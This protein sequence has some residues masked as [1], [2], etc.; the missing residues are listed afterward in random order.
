[1]M[2]SFPPRSGNQK[3]NP[4]PDKNR[5]SGFSSTTLNCITELK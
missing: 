3:E 2:P 5:I 1:M 4:L